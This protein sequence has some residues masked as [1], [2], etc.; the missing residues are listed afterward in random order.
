MLEE[1]LKTIDQCGFPRK[2]KVW[3]LQFMLIPK[4]LRPLMIFDI[5]TSAVEAM[6]TKINKFS[7]K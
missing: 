1:G 4:F 6:E 2:Y 7:R 5:C 3:C